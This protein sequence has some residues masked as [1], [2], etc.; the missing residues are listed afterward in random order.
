LHV[1]RHGSRVRG[2]EWALGRAEFDRLIT[3]ACVYCG[4]PPL[5]PYREPG[6][7]YDGFTYN[8]I[9]RVDNKLGYVPGNVVTCCKVCNHAKW[10]MGQAEFVAWLDRVT[11][12]RGGCDGGSPDHH[13]TRAR[14]P[15]PKG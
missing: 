12:Y 11:A 1:Y 13:P 3:S 10:N 4:S 5:T 9:D 7:T 15:A 2:W 6:R 14:L 8:G